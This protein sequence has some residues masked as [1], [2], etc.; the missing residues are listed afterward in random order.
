MTKRQGPAGAILRDMS[1]ITVRDLV[2]ASDKKDSTERER[3]EVQLTTVTGKIARL[4]A[5]ITDEDDTDALADVIL[6]L[7]GDEKALRIGTPS[8]HF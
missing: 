4:K 7:S 3:L 6:S 8:P 5:R 2:P 1:E